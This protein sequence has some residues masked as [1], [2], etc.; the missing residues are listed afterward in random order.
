MARTQ[1]QYTLQDA[2]LDELNQWA[3][4]VLEKRLPNTIYG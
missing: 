3:P 4:R 2:T 1:Y